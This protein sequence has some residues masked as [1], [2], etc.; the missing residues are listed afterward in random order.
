M[1]NEHIKLDT[2]IWYL[3]LFQPTS[4]Q[5]NQILIGTPSHSFQSRVDGADNFQLEASQC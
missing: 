3:S 1:Y 5:D 2:P 4:D